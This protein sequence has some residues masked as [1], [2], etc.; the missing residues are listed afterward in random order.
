MRGYPNEVM[1]IY[2][3]MVGALHNVEMWGSKR[4]DRV[5]SDWPNRI[6]LYMKKMFK[7]CMKTILVEK[8]LY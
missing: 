1:V 2:I 5:N 8:F 4:A 7:L 3:I 6:K